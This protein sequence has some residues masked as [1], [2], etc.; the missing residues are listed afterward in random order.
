MKKKM[1]ITSKIF[2]GLISG[3]IAGL[4]VYQLKGNTFVD[5]YIIGF[6]FYLVGTV[7][8]N[9]IKM[10]VVPLVFV[11][12]TIGVTSVSNAKKLGRIGV[13]TIAFY[14]I[15]TAI[16]VAISIVLSSYMQPGSGFELSSNSVYEAKEVPKLIEVIINIIQINPIDWLAKGKIIQIIVLSFFLGIAIT[17]LGDKAIK[18]K[19]GFEA[20][21]KVI[22]KLVMIIMK[23]APYGV[24]AWV[25]KIFFEFGYGAMLPLLK[26][27]GCVLLALIIHVIITYQGLLF[28]FTRLNPFRFFKNFVPAMMVAFSTVSSL[29]TLP[30]TMEI[31]EERF[32]VSKCVASFTLPLG[33]KI[34]MD[35][36]A[37]M[38]GVATVF[39]AQAYGL[40]LGIDDFLTVIFLIII[41]T[42]T[43][44]SIGRADIPGVGVI[45]LSM[46]LT[47]INI[48]VEGIVI[49][50]GIDRILDMCRTVINIT[51]DVVCTLI[52]SKQEEKFNKSLI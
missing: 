35:G 41:L 31:A 23:F 13:K 44:A 39:L 37:I 32:G 50:M 27:M 8:I 4:I 36:T 40:P 9:S 33:A 49:I 21:N 38:Q 47:E 28:V 12:L 17:F 3:I 51:G 43:I 22:L 6:F 25:G 42:A 14:L 7:F 10:V 46:I 11:S 26:Y 45:M 30:I 48:P 52:I 20:L 15:T 5:N 34:N 29:S 18:V 19:E 1:N 24:F 2:I 16:A